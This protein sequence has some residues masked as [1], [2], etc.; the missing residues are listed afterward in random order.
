[1]LNQA[2]NGA[3]D[4]MTPPKDQLHRVLA[5]SAT[6]GLLV[7]ATGRPWSRWRVHGHLCRRVLDDAGRIRNLPAWALETGA[8]VATTHARSEI[9]LS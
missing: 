9:P 5:G 2:F 6:A 3:G 1:M 7:S 8:G 4:T